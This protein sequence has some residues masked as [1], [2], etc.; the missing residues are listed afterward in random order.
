MDAENFVY[1]RIPELNSFL[2]K[3]RGTM[4]FTDS[5]TI[6]SNIE[7]LIHIQKVNSTTWKSGNFISKTPTFG[8]TLFFNKGFL[9]TNYVSATD[10]G[11][12]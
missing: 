2:S 10:L 7:G 6:I 5:F 9:S 1:T 8:P 4:L 11:T 3:V 12:G